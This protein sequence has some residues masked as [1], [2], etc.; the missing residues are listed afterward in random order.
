MLIQSGIWLLLLDGFWIL[1]V[2]VLFCL[3]SG[4]DG[5]TLRHCEGLVHVCQIYVVAV[6]NI[7]ISPLCGTFPAQL[8]TATMKEEIVH[9]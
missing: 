5:Y 2:D 1:C 4:V 9:N 8:K 7:L 3:L 6:W